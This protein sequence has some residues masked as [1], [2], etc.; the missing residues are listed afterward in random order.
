MQN[1]R[2]CRN[3]SKDEKIEHFLWFIIISH[4][5]IYQHEEICYLKVTTQTNYIEADSSFWIRWK[6]ERNLPIFF[7]KLPSKTPKSDRI[8]RKFAM[9]IWSI[10]RKTWDTVIFFSK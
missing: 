2:F 4:S 6:P 7:N 10:E 5:R 1:S 8:R 9:L 3:N